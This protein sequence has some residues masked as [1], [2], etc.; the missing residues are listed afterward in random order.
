VGFYYG[1]AY[2]LFDL[3]KWVCFSLL[4]VSTVGW[5]CFSF[6]LGFRGVIGSLFSGSCSH[7]LVVS[8]HSTGRSF[9]CQA[10]SEG[11]SWGIAGW[12]VVGGFG[13]HGLHSGRMSVVPR[14]VGLST[15]VHSPRLQ[16]LIN[17]IKKKKKKKET[18]TVVRALHATI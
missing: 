6:R 9:L 4:V 18:V 7:L 12:T 8:T 5:G 1:L 15:G 17:K 10:G 16:Q 2:R 3:G 13:Q 11:F 14:T